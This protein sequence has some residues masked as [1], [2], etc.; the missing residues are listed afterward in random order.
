MTRLVTAAERAEVGR[1]LA[2]GAAAYRV[3]QEMQM[4]ATTVRRIRDELR[5]PALVPGTD[6][7]AKPEAVRWDDPPEVDGDPTE[8]N[9]HRYPV[10]HWC[11]ER[12]HQARWLEMCDKASPVESVVLRDAMCR[13][14]GLKLAATTP[15]IYAALAAERRYAD[16][17]AR[18]YIQVR[19]R[20]W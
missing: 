6:R 20:G 3:A 9:P 4:P 1:R 15:E 19:G 11:V 2:S 10:G 17:L 7:L 16:D 18:L 8:A 5:I 14:L 13:V 12:P